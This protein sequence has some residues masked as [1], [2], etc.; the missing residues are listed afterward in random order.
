MHF[1]Y[2]LPWWL[3]IAL[4]AAVGTAGVFTRRPLSADARSAAR[5]SRCARSSGLLVLF[6]FRPI[7]SPPRQPVLAT[8][9]CRCFVDVSRSMRLA[10]ADGGSRAPKPQ[11]FLKTQPIPA[12][13]T[14]FQTELFSVGDGLAPVT[15]EGLGAD[16]R[17]TDLAGSLSAVRERYRGQRIAGVIVVGRRGHWGRWGR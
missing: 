6:F 15:M 16:A 1:A 8:L 17:R 12:L 11:R 5:W 13:S 2:A 10:D 4:A 3:A 14:H 7:A 9:S